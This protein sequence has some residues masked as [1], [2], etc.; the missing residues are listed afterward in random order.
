VLR[1][2]A[3]EVVEFDGPVL[4]L[5][6][7]SRARFDRRLA[8]GAATLDRARRQAAYLALQREWLAYHCTI[9]LYEW[10]EV[11]QVAETLHN[12]APAGGPAVDGWNAAD[13]WLG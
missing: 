12:F 10:P 5:L 3:H 1:T 11:R 6:T 8:A 2:P 13:W 9:T 4:E 7:E